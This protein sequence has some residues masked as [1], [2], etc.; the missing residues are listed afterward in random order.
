MND[1]SAELQ[2]TKESLDR[3]DA[4]LSEFKKHLE[5][6]RNSLNGSGGMNAITET[7]DVD[8]AL[9]VLAENVAACQAGTVF[10]RYND[11]VTAE[12]RARDVVRSTIKAFG[13]RLVLD[14]LFERIFLDDDLPFSLVVTCSQLIFGFD[15]L[16]QH[17]PLAPGRDGTNAVVVSSDTNNNGR[18]PGASFVPQLVPATQRPWKVERP[19]DGQA[20]WWVVGPEQ[21]TGRLVLVAA[22]ETK[23]DADSIALACNAHADLLKALK[24]VRVYLQYYATPSEERTDLDRALFIEMHKAE[25]RLLP[26]PQLAVSN[27]GET[28]Q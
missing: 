17:P 24:M 11:A 13:P 22:C 7:A 14:M 3:C 19:P 18:R 23:E 20:G 12:R 5:N 10:N 27:D 2:G 16:H 26:E 6:A 28:P 25:G 1:L 15:Q 9:D 21:E 8:A 4:L